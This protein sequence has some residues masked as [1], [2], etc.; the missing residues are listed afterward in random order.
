MEF[1]IQKLI[2]D[3]IASERTPRLPQ[4][5]SPSKL[6]SC[7]CGVYLERLGVKP[8]EDFDERTLRVFKIGKVFEDWVVELVRK[9]STNIETQVEFR[10]E[11]YDVHGFVDLVVDKKL[12]YEIKSKHSKGFWYMDKKKEGANQHHKEQ[13]WV[14]MKCLNIPES[15]IIYLSKD[16]LAILEYPIFLD[17]KELEQSV[18]SQL[19]ILNKAWKEKVPPAPVQDPKDWRATYCRW[20][21]T[22]L[23]QEKYL[24][25]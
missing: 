12:I 8:D 23:S 25:L 9:Q 10:W 18:I 11:E 6:G 20:H 3:Q 14:Y 15:R 2:N 7:L 19:E 24:D 17:D 1:S 4:S 16:D 21:K 22:C 13:V 5:F